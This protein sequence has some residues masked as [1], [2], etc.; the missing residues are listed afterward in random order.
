MIETLGIVFVIV[1]ILL[2]LLAS[3]EGWGIPK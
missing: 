1:G 3:S 2:I